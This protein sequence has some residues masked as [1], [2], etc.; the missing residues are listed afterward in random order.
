MSIQ[1]RGL[2]RRP[3][4]ID[5]VASANS[6]AKS[7]SL[8]SGSST[9]VRNLKKIVEND[10]NISASS[11]AARG[12]IRNEFFPLPDSQEQLEEV[13]EEERRCAKVVV[14]L[15]NRVRQG[16]F[17]WSI[18]KVALQDLGP[19]ATCLC[20][21]VDESALHVLFRKRLHIRLALQLTIQCHTYLWHYTHL[22]AVLLLLSFTWE[23]SIHRGPSHLVR[24]VASCPPQVLTLQG[25]WDRS[26]ICA[27][28]LSFTQE[29]WKLSNPWRHAKEDGNLA[30]WGGKRWWNCLKHFNKHKCINYLNKSRSWPLLQVLIAGSHYT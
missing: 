28:E 12:S 11:L 8:Q 30:F 5:T 3:G 4:V 23:L 13:M 6:N 26:S 17:V 15:E 16:G 20:V 9:W 29:R 10:W 2:L 22:S 19:S 25:L 27:S 7:V 18:P 21:L 24:V 14:A 1:G